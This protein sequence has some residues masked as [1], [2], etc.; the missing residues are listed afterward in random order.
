MKMSKPGLCCEKCFAKIA[1]RNTKAARIWLNLCEIQKTSSVFG[2][3]MPDI[4]E[5][6]VLEKLGFI[7]STETNEMILIKVHGKKVD[8]LGLFFCGGNCSE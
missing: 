1:K 5:F 7:T 6:R 8:S 3:Y 2:I 4:P